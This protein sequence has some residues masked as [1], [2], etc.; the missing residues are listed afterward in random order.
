[1]PVDISDVTITQGQ[2]AQTAGN[3]PGSAASG[4]ITNDL[5][6]QVV[7]RVMELLLLDLKYERER[8]RS[9]GRPDRLKGVR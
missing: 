9:V 2:N 3:P 7:E 8:R 4:E 1:M 5:V 6:N